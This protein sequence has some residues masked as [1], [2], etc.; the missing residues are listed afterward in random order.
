MNTVG[1]A[2]GSSDVVTRAN[3]AALSASAELRSARDALQTKIWNAQVRVRELSR[4]I[5]RVEREAF[6]AVVKG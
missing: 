1:M 6:Q 5:T 3:A 4:E 2:I